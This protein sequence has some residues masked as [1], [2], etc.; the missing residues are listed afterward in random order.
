MKT[1]NP[2]VKLT[3]VRLSFP[4]LF[5]PKPDTDDNGAVKPDS[6]PK[7]AATFLLDKKRNAADI[8][9]LQAAIAEVKKSPVIKGKPVRYIGLRDGSEKSHVG[10]YGEGIM[11]ITARNT[12]KPFVV[13][14]ATNQISEEKVYAGCYVNAVVSCYAYVHPKS[15][16]G[17]TFSLGNVQHVR[18][19]EPFG[20]KRRDPSE[21]FTAVEEDADAV[22]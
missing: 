19:G 14:R 13:D 21:D 2:T 12:L 7:Y 3:N 1:Q 11:F 9:A 17:I 15:G 20:E 10:G 8:A 18:D 22:V 6:K 5:T 4:V 16:A